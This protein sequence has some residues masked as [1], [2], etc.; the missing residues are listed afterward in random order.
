M[1]SLG[2]RFYLISFIIKQN[3]GPRENTLLKNGEN[4]SLSPISVQMISYAISYKCRNNWPSRMHNLFYYYLSLRANCFHNDGERRT[5]L[6]DTGLVS[7]DFLPYKLQMRFP[8]APKNAY[9]F[10]IIMHFWGPEERTLL[11]NSEGFHLDKRR[12]ANLSLS[13]FIS[14]CRWA[15]FNLILGRDSSFIYSLLVLKLYLNPTAVFK[16]F[17]RENAI[18]FIV[19]NRY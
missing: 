10:F 7:N 15:A 4:F 6:F 12:A 17:L 13:V 14:M 8:P 3:R 1:V 19:E 18:T 9:S 2:P 5:K 11:K 16:C